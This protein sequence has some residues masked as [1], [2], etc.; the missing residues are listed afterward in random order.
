MATM[1]SRRDRRNIQAIR[2]IREPMTTPAQEMR[3]ATV[4]AVTLAHRRMRSL[5]ST[6]A[7]NL[8]FTVNCHTVKM[9]SR[10]GNTS[11]MTLLG[12]KML[13]R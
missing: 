10:A 1:L 11:R 4:M 8:K 6:S 2:S 12:M 7:N 13:R 3:V 5:R 9:S